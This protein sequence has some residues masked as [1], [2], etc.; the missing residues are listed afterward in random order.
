MCSILSEK[1][2]IKK[3]SYPWQMVKKKKNQYAKL[4]L[5][6]RTI[7][8]LLPGGPGGPASPEGPGGP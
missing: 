8:T 7:H 5:A 6:M 3:V 1:I 2:I 4:A